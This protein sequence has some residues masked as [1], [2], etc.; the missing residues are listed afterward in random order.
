MVVVWNTVYMQ[1]VAAQLRREG[2]P[3]ADENLHFDLGVLLT[4]EWDLRRAKQRQAQMRLL[5]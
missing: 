4:V 5:Y 2:Q 1:G 3:V